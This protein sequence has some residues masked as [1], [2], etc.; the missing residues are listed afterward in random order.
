[1]VEGQAGHREPQHAAQ[2]PRRAEPVPLVQRTQPEA[3]ALLLLHGGR[4]RTAHGTVRGGW[5]LLITSLMT[6]ARNCVWF[7][8]PGSVR[9]QADVAFDDA[10]LLVAIA[11][12]FAGVIGHRI[13]ADGAVEAPD[14]THAGFQRTRALRVDDHVVVEA[15]AILAGAAVPVI[16]LEVRLP[17]V[18]GQLVIASQ[19]QAD[20]AGP[21]VVVVEA[22]ARYRIATVIQRGALPDHLS[23]L[24]ASTDTLVS[25]P[26]MPKPSPREERTRPS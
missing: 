26:L 24:P 13:G 14:H 3:T 10:A 16:E 25:S 11:A 6:I 18:V 17:A 20:A 9:A 23:G 7:C 5:G 15:D 21:G 19:A 4:S 22:H 12:Q 8:I 2:A 1:M